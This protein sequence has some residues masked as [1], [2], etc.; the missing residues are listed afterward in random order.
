MREG[1]GR[2]SQTDAEESGLHSRSPHSRGT[3]GAIPI[4]SLLSAP[5]ALQRHPVPALLLPI[6]AQ[7]QGVLCKTKKDGDRYVGF[8]D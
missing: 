3:E 6:I 5:E 8:A 7:H 1:M 2:G 4:R